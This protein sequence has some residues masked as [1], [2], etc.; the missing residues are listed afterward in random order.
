MVLQHHI[1]NSLSSS[2]RSPNT[3]QI[4][5]VIEILIQLCLPDMTIGA[6]SASVE[7]KKD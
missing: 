6:N 2:Q 7:L 3:D 4:V 5:A 1:D